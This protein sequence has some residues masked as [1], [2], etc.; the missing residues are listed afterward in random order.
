MTKSLPRDFHFQKI[1]TFENLKTDQGMGT[2]LIT[3][4]ANMVQI[5]ASITSAVQCGFPLTYNQLSRSPLNAQV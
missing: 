4:Y 2:P 1:N 3:C 5:R